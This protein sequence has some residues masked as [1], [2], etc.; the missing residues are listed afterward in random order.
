MK[1]F[2]RIIGVKK[3]SELGAL[4][5]PTAEE[6]AWVKRMAPAHTC[7]P[8]GIFKYRSPEA[9]SAD[10]DRWQVDAIKAGVN[11]GGRTRE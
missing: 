5:A 2:S 11:L 1:E 6:R 7:V 10:W 3:M 8:K 4:R 9:A